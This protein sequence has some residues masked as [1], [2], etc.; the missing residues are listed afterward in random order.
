MNTTTELTHAEKNRLTD[1]CI[2]NVWLHLPVVLSAVAGT[3]WLAANDY[4]I[5]AVI[6]GVGAIVAIGS[7]FR[8]MY[9]PYTI[10][11]LAT[12]L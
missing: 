2:R 5:A 4:K 12:E 10:T 9:L 11:V 8:Q 3:A 1:R 6:V 7:L